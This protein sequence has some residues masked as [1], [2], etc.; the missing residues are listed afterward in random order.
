MYTVHI[1]CMYD[2]YLEYE[3]D[4]LLA[5]GDYAVVQRRLYNIWYTL[6]I[7]TV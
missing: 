7:Y 4:E 6:Y 1:Y 5:V 3:Y 2:V